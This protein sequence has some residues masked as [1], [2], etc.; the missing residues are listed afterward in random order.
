MI[1][2]CS[3]FKH[4]NDINEADLIL[5]LFLASSKIQDDLSIKNAGDT[6]LRDMSHEKVQLPL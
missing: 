2:L 3:L 4:L 6:I 1:L 5:D